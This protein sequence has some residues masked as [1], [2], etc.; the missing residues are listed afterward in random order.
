VAVVA[1]LSKGYD[2][3]YIWKQVD[4][5]PAKD[6]ASYYIQASESGGEPP[7]RWWGPGAKALGFEPGQT[8]ERKPY[9]LLFGERK[10][11][12]GTPLGRSPGS[13]RK[14]A[15]LYAR[16]L[17]AEPHATAERKRELRIEAT[18]QARQSPLYFDLT[19]SFSKSISI[20]HASLGENARLARQ[21]GDQAGDRYWTTLVTEVDD[22]IWQAVHSGF[23]YFQR[24]AG[25][26]RT[27]SHNTRVHGRETGQWHEA[28]LAVAHW[29]QHTSRDGDMQLHV[30]SQI[31]HTARTTTDGKWRAPDS[32]GYNEH[33][34]AV[35]A[36]VSQHLEEALT[37]RFGVEWV[38]RDDGHGFEI[39]GISGQ[40]MRV[41]SSR[42]ESITADLR[43]RATQFEQRYGRKPSQREMAQLAQAS[44]FKTRARKDG[45][46]D[47]A[48]LHAGW[49]DKL[50]R[51]LG[52][53][54]ASVAPSVWHNSSG[55]TAVQPRDSDG[56]RLS[57]LEITRAA[58]KAVALAQQEKST[59]GRAD[60]V[61]YLGRVLPRTGTESAAAAALLEDLADRALR[62][63]FEPV[64]CL[65]A[66][67]PVEVPRSLLRADG[68]SIYQRHGGVRYA[69]RAQLTMEERMLAQARATDAPR[70]TRTEAARAFGA[71]LTRLE[72]ALDGRTHDARS[73]RTRTGLRED[74]AAAAL[75][76]LTDGKRVSVLNAPAGSGKTWVLAEAGRAWTAAGRGPVIGITP[77]QSARNTLAAGVPVS[78]NT[79]QF[80]GHLPGQ[81][82]ARGPIP[83]GPGAL[84]LIDE[85]S[86]VPGPD[87]ADVTSLA[88]ATGS[89]VILAGDTAQLQ[90]VEN[91]GG[92]SL[93]AD[94]LGYVQLAEPVR[95]RDEWERAASLRLRAGDTA[96]LADYDQHARIRGGEPEQ[97]MDAAA[98]AYVALTLDGTDTLLMAADH[99]LRREL[100]RRI[101]DD[102]ISLGVV[103]A[104]P[105]VRIADGAQASTGDLIICTKNDHEVQAG[106]PGRTLANGDLLRIEAVTGRGLMVRRALDA[107]PHTGQR[108]WTDQRF[109]FAGYKHSELGY[110]VTD[111]VAQGRTVHTGLA[112]ITGTEDRPHAV[113]ALTR[114]TD[115]NMA[116]V[117]RLSPKRADPM[118]GPRPAPELARYD[119]LTAGPGSQPGTEPA[120]TAKPLEALAAVLDRDGQQLSA[121]QTRQQG[122]SDA[123][124][125]AALH[126]IWTA[127]TAPAREQRYHHLFRDAL[128]PGYRSEPGHQ[129]KWLWRTLRAAELAGLDAGQVLAA[130]IAER[131]LAG[132]RDIPSVIEARIRSRVGPLVPL[133]AGPWSAQVPAIADPERRAFA[134]GIAAMM[135][136]CKDRIGEHAAEHAVPWAVTALG[137]VPEHPLDRLDWQRRAASVGAYRELAG[138]D[139]PADPIGPE[140][141]AG[142]P[143][144][145][146][147]WYEALAAL[148]PVDGPAV[149]GMPDGTLLHLRDTYPVETAWAP[150]WVGDELRQ[151]R[152]G[153]QDAH[154][155]ATRADAEAQAATSRGQTEAA[156]GHQVLAASYRAMHD[157]YRD[158]ETV[159]AAVMADRADWDTATR[160]QRHL[161]VAA[162]A[163]LR[164]RHPGQRFTPLRSAEPPPATDAQRDDL[165]LAAGQEIKEMGQWIKDLAAERRTF[166]DQLAERQTLMIPAEDPG[167]GDLGQAFP[168][169][170]GFG[171][172]AILQPPKPQIPPSARILQRVADR[173]ADREAAD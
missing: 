115:T 63:E 139:H 72:D 76:V 11:P 38:A 131:D 171:Q 60:L 31:A 71:D 165:T 123:D 21:V 128:P 9:D 96:V 109:L 22:M 61:K 169:W 153:A 68:R 67:E 116:Y 27:G 156:A 144:R 152:A 46:L 100:S 112:V 77:S 111:H 87:M 114:G 159:F 6:A 56:R 105:A 70:L 43:T 97:M 88:E 91:G 40:M 83:T 52:I 48:Q 3:D 55:H 151:V 64:E 62:S 7:G 108:R 166:A 49:A 117:F 69:T 35:A 57:Q 23:G 33:I 36:V 65:E 2:L 8:V 79:A 78:Y 134:A 143:D 173:D 16:L 24:E 126:A 155:A 158:R 41:F 19:I 172:D 18:R 119:Q 37:R 25:Y 39:K 15:D 98:A 150:Q 162:D 66:P 149:R 50:A 93:L 42:R 12:D 110:A 137:P 122:L 47:F 44:N 53:P 13:G 142:A 104:G 81:R 103:Q 34:G 161:A 145:R 28:D 125:L 94:E 127:E 86:M 80:L 160:A 20:F 95:F 146:A 51:T 140:P 141:V 113:V 1:T 101:R 4:R 84:L 135:D 85:A 73:Q 82:G 136:A 121:V 26:T 163:E 129:A 99:A 133:P 17:A 106:E 154:L 168:A 107:D 124:H 14:A 120:G 102:L 58:Q 157:A 164:R 32:L 45:T 132:A 30:H 118:P 5:G 90:A 54:L 89:K 29:L 148:G 147:A 170:A 74:Q 59:W 92:M 10:A 138:H 130:A 167:Y 75:S